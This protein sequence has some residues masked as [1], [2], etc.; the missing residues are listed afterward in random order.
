MDAELEVIRGF[1]KLIE[2]E[3][4]I[5]LQRLFQPTMKKQGKNKSSKPNW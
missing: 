2:Q 4:P 5:S 3:N 1:Y